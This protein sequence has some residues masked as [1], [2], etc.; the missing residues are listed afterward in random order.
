[1]KKIQSVIIIALIAFC[2]FAIMACGKTYH[3]EIEQLDIKVGE[4]VDIADYVDFDFGLSMSNQKVLSGISNT[5]ICGR[6]PGQA[7]VTVIK[8]TFSHEITVNVSYAEPELSVSCSSPL[9]TTM[10]GSYMTFTADLGL[11]SDPSK[12]ITWFMGEKTVGVGKTYTLKL[13]DYGRY[14]ITAKAAEDMQTVTAVCFKPFENAPII[15]CDG[16]AIVSL[17]KQLNFTAEIDKTD[18]SPRIEWYVNNEKIQL[19]ESLEFTFLPQEVGKYTVFAC[20]NGIKTNEISFI[21]SGKAELKNV[22][23]DFDSDYPN[24]YLKWDSS[25]EAKYE[26]TVDGRTL[27]GEENEFDV[28]DLVD[29]KKSSNI[30]LRCLGGEHY[31]PSEA[32]TIVTPSLSDEA[33]TYL[34]KRYFDGNYYMSSDEEVYDFVEYAMIFRP[35]SEKIERG[36]KINF[37]LYMGYDSDMSAA[38]LLSKAWARTEQTGSYQMQAKGGMS[39]GSTPTFEI[40][41][42]TTDEPDKFNTDGKPSYD[43]LYTPKFGSGI[44]KLPI[45]DFKSGG[46]VETSDELQYVVQKGYAPKPVSGSA[47]ERIYNKAKEI[48]SKILSEDMDDEKKTRA[49]FDWVMWNTVYDYSVVTNDVSAAVRE[50]AFYLEGVFD[51]GF[52]VCDGIAKSISLMCNMAGVPC[53]RVVGF[54]DNGIVSRH[55]WN[56]VLIDGEWYIVDATWSD[57]RA[58][59]AGKTYEGALHEYYLRS[60]DEMPTHKEIYPQLYPRAEHIYD[61]YGKNNISVSDSSTTELLNIASKA[62]ENISYEVKIGDET[63]VRDHYC[64][65]IALS[66]KAKSAFKFNV[67]EVTRV[68]ELALK[69]RKFTWTILNDLLVIVL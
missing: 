42:M 33:L 66:Q 67:G 64:I 34:N 20:V 54:A 46:N 56:K 49:I 11:N 53:M 57:S 15:T 43:S 69:G 61:W 13:E 39:K 26:V 47:A 68:L 27:Y 4:Y 1:M 12:Q 37:N 44:S 63:T 59:V 41:F 45:N 65:E 21:V 14:E 32:V 25:I 22:R 31:S 35:N 62:A 60:D 30:T 10:T 36:E 28:T 3:V 6:A 8:G 2:A 58:I 38:L 55:A 52:A 40:S 17:G 23:F 24:L 9:Y 18:F 16:S 29:L 7:T 51:T 48:L 50:P 5:V 19:G